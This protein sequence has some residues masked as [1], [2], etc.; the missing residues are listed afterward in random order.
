MARRKSGFLSDGSDSDESASGSD[1][2]YNS[3]ED[4]DSR[5]ERRLFENE[6]NKR[7][8][9]GRKEQAWEGIFGEEDEVSARALGARRKA[10]TIGKRSTKSVDL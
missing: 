6:G 2:G 3:Q 10:P 5:A 7:R 1:A 8:K 9:T 4:D